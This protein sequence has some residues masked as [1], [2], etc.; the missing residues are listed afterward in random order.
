MPFP[1]SRNIWSD[2]DN[3]FADPDNSPSSWK[4]IPDTMTT[5]TQAK[6]STMQ[7]SPSSKPH[8]TQI[9][10]DMFQQLSS[11]PTPP[12]APKT[13]SSSSP[14]MLLLRVFVFIFVILW[15]GKQLVTEI[16]RLAENPSLSR[17]YFHFLLTFTFLSLLLVNIHTNWVYI[18]GFLRRQQQS[19]TRFIEKDSDPYTS[20]RRVAQG[21]ISFLKHGKG[22]LLPSFF[23]PPT[24]STIIYR[25]MISM[26]SIIC[27]ILFLH[28]YQLPSMTKIIATEKPVYQWIWWMLSKLLSWSIWF[29]GFSTFLLRLVGVTVKDFTVYLMYQIIILIAFVMMALYIINNRYRS[30]VSRALYLLDRKA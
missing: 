7:S 12:I 13:M 25:F 15:V 28:I 22:V 4:F 10:T 14:L 19:Y 29:V 17:L 27:T 2:P 6:K 30:F 8:K 16:I 24:S 26:T 23:S 21:S 5:T 20:A 11:I 18:F 1:P 9:Y 3:P